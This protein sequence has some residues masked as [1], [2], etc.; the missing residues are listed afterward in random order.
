MGKNHKQEGLTG[1]QRALL[2]IADDIYDSGF[3]DGFNEGG[4]VESVS[5]FC[6]RLLKDRKKQMGK[7][8]DED[9]EKIYISAHLLSVACKWNGKDIARAFCE[10]L[11]DANF[12]KERKALAPEINR[13]FGTDIAKEG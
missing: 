3:G 8:F 11:T 12:H 10:A 6:A 1:D 13:L 2:K 5:L 9:K 7:D 4:P